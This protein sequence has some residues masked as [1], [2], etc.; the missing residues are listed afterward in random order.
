MSNYVLGTDAS[1]LVR[2]SLQQAVWGATTEALLAAMGLR[3]G[4]RVADL[5]CGPGLVLPSLRARV[6]ASGR[7]LAV[8]ESPEW[9]RHL[10]ADL[11]RKGWGNVTF[12]R[13]RLEDLAL[14]PAGFDGLFARWVL[15]FLPGVP[16]LLA[17]LA[18]ALAP[19]GAIGLQDYNHEGVSLFPSSEGFRAVVRATRALYASRGGDPWIAGRLPGMLRA[20]GLVVEHRHVDVLC[21]GPDSPAFRWADAFFPHHSAG[22]VAAGLLSPDERSRFLDEWGERRADPDA[23]FF[24]PM[25]V[26]LVARRPA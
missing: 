5:G 16:A 9:E 12:Q 10:L 1:E 24:S 20:A 21:G 3:E 23:M 4:A 18:R 6:G 19:G 7:V 14:A 11:A 8:D 26:S 17:R 25:V 22:M 15:S 13:A 2:L